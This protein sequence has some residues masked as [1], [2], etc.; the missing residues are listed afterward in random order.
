MG[1]SGPE[2]APVDN[3]LTF[4][5]RLSSSLEKNEV[6]RRA[7]YIEVLAILNTNP[8]LSMV[9]QDPGNMVLLSDF[10]ETQ[11]GE[12]V[13]GMRLSQVADAN[14]EELIFTNKG[15]VMLMERVAMVGQVLT[16]VTDIVAAAE[17]SVGHAL[18]F[19]YRSPSLDKFFSTPVGSLS[20]RELRLGVSQA[21][22][23]F[24][25]GLGKLGDK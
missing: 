5:D 25:H 22:G 11:T 9:I 14:G 19:D 2:Y 16:V 15:R 10:G 13:S 18:V 23:D 17:Q 7:G 24:A 20:V 4:A 1:R 8:V 6:G 3:L 21:I 12:R